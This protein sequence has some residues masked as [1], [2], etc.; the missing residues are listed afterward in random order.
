MARMRAI[1]GIGLLLTLGVALA[2]VSAQPA[3]ADPI[4]TGT[5]TLVREYDVTFIRQ[6]AAIDA[7]HVYAVSNSAIGKY[8][9]NS[10]ARVGGW[11]MPTDGPIRHINSCFAERQLLWCANS[12]YPDVPMGSSIE[13]FDSR[14]M[15]HVRSHSLGLMDEGSLVWFD[16]LG[17]GWIAGFAHYDGRGGTGYKGQKYGAIIRFDSAW[18][19]TGGW[20]IPDAVLARMAPHAASGGAIGPDGLLYLMGHDRP[21]LYVLAQP[22]MGPVLVHLA[23]L[24]IVAEGQAF[25]WEKGKRRQ[26]AA[27]SRKGGAIRIFDVPAVAMTAANATRFAR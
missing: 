10:G 25:A 23:T 16:R 8:D 6:G 21:E 2:S 20:L 11:E 22:A 26:I 1:I 14:R 18:R 27:M 3:P 24:N 19:R 12:N 5:L 17:D 9:R 15:A 4:Q 7:A 13:V